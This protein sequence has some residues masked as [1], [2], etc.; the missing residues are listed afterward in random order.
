MYCTREKGSE[1]HGDRRDRK[2]PAGACPWPS[3]SSL[4]V[5]TASPGL[6]T[7]SSQVFRL[8]G[9][10]LSSLA[11]QTFLKHS[12]KGP[13]RP[14]S[15]PLSPHAPF[16]ASPPW[17]LLVPC[18]LL[19]PPHRP[20]LLSAHSSGCV[21]AASSFPP[22]TPNTQQWQLLCAQHSYVLAAVLSTR[23]S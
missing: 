16:P 18:V 4:P 15:R 14:H 23:P 2:G 5:S 9:T 17:G 6:L 1:I 21:W 10:P 12:F 22:A 19:E 3:W 11:C 7:A 8:P 20:C 13:P